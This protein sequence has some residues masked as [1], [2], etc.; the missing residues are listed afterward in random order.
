[1]LPVR[2]L[3]YSLE[4]YIEWICNGLDDPKLCR[5]TMSLVEDAVHGFGNDCTG[6]AKQYTFVLHKPGG[7]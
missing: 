3:D 6:N 4:P 7:C 2:F 1:M 5:L